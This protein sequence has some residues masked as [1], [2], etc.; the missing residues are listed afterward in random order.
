MY[1]VCRSH[2][3]YH[4]ISPSRSISYYTNPS[5][6]SSPSSLSSEELHFYSL[7]I[8]FTEED[9]NEGRRDKFLT[10]VD[11]P[12]DWLLTPTSRRHPTTVI[13]LCKI[14]EQI[15]LDLFLQSVRFFPWVRHHFTEVGESVA[16][17]C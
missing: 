5:P 9:I 7:S 4:N 11:D 10:L 2:S 13:C 12:S 17:S 3:M 6:P 8:S 14:V 1:L 15:E 16:R